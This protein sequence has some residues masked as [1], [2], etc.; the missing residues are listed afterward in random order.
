MTG[1]DGR[2]YVYVVELARPGNPSNPSVYVGSS[3]LPPEER[4]RRHKQGGVP[5]SG[6]V[7]RQGIRL[8]PDLYRNMNP[9]TSRADA[10]DAEL[11]LRHALEG[12]GYRVFGSCSP[13]KNGCFF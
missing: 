11:G 8:R 3:A 4:F 7:R 12:R 6:M 1:R 2:F 9:L 5:T 10:R 13:R